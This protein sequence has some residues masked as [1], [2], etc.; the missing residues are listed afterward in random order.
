MKDYLG[1]VPANDAEGVLQDIHWS[2]GS[3]GYFSTYALGNLISVQLWEKYRATNPAA[4]DQIRRGDFSA[5]LAWLRDN[6]HRHGRK[7]Q[8]RELVRQA[9]GSSIDPAPYLHYLET[10]YSDVYKL[11]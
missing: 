6:I 1:V 3:M 9:T 2:M 4:E 10:K 11:D 7:Y 5:L 8:P